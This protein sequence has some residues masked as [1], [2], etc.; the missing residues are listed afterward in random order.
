MKT[1]NDK[2]LANAALLFVLALFVVILIQ[3][4]KA[5]AYSLTNE[6]VLQKTSNDEILIKPQQLKTMQLQ[7]NLKEYTLLDLSSSLQ[8][9]ADF[10]SYL[11]IP[12]AGILD[13]K[14]LK[15]IKKTDKLL[16]VAATESEAAMAAQLLISKGI[17][18][19]SVLSNNA[20]FTDRVLTQEMDAAFFDAHAEKA[21]YDYGR[22]LKNQSSGAKKASKQAEIPGGVK[23]VAAAGGC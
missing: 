11:G 23:V 17:A 19:V 5:P 7:K 18:N 15:S 12:F 22:F 8:N 3:W 1:I 2:M 4:W 16:V 6:A 9:K 13:S 10:G 20:S 21:R 14:N